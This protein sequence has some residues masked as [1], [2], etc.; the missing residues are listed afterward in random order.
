MRAPD[1]TSSFSVQIP[2][3][4]PI[5]ALSQRFQQELESVNHLLI[6]QLQNPVP[7]I[8][9]LGKHL[10]ASGGKRLRPLLT[11]ASAKLCGYKEQRHI[12]LAACIEF[13]HG[14]TLLHDD[15]IDESPKRRGV[16][17][18]H[19]LWGNKASILVG[20]FLFSRAFQLMVKYGTPEILV[21]L[22]K[23]AATIV[24]GE[25]HQLTTSHELST[26]IDAYF[27]M[28]EA[29]T[30]ALFAASC[31]IGAV[32][33]SQPEL[34]QKALWDYGHNLGIAFQLMDDVLDYRPSSRERGKA[35][36]DDFHEGKVTLPALLAYQE[37]DETERA[38]WQRALGHHDQQPN[39]LAQALTLFE[40]HEVFSAIHKLA[41][42]YIK[43]AHTALSPF[44]PTP[45]CTLLKEVA[46]FCVEGYV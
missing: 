1:H 28:I 13:I 22:S 36:G 23:A 44:P 4:T 39:D 20:D 21:I 27:D 5:D 19:T 7:L 15:V 2:I 10:I 46:T 16:P 31:E 11:L 30:A 32:L 37:G 42:T 43:Q 35:L 14:A 25:V 45:L 38:F 40:K 8:P 26:P 24:Q 18:A 9:E 34:I 33:A 29:K 6:N 17:T 12:V 3:L 41:Q